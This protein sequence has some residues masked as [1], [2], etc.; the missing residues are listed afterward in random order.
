MA[1]KKT[2]SSKS[3]ASGV[4]IDAVD[5]AVD[6]AFGKNSPVKIPKDQ[7]KNIL[8]IM[9][10]VLFSAGVFMVLH[11][12]DYIDIAR[13]GNNA[14][15]GNFVDINGP[16]LWIAAVAGFAATAAMAFGAFQ[17]I[18]KN[19]D[20]VRIAIYGL[21]LASA[22]RLIASFGVSG[23]FDNFLIWTIIYVVMIILLAQARESHKD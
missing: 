14:F 4:K 2:S 7:H 20:G 21:I 17:M 9:P 22:A 5:N 3:K 8:M 18:S 19:V 16:F 15:I 6:K 12:L 13:I 23:I 11:A 1:E 10:W